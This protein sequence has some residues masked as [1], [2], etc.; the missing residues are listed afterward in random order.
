LPRWQQE[1]APQ[2][3]YNLGVAHGTPAVLV[4]LGAVAAIGIKADLATTLLEGGVSWL[5]AQ[6]TPAMGGPV[7]PTWVAEDGVAPEARLGWCYGDAGIAGAL[8]CIALTA[9]RDDW[10][11]EA[12]DLART[13]ATG[14]P[15]SAV[16]N[17]PGL[18]HGAS[19]LA[20][21]FARLHHQSGERVFHA[22]GAAW[23]SHALQMQRPDEGV[24]GFWSFDHDPTQ[25]RGDASFLN[26]ASGVGLALLS[27]LY[28]VPP[29]WH[30]LL[31]I[32]SPALDQAAYWTV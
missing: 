6:R 7:F 13:V 22:A 28:D 17:E 16:V 26:G 32:T 31:A 27:V 19:G 20:T 14:A 21:L 29:L 24:G 10:S 2:G 25:S 3:Y 1:L 23:T 8:H 18:C 4:V 5:L 30:R 15:H 9:G 11:Q 12:L